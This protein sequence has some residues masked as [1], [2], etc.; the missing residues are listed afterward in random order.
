MYVQIRFTLSGKFKIVPVD[1]L[2][3][4]KPNCPTKIC[5]AKDGD[6]YLKALVISVRNSEKE[7]DE[8]AESV[9]RRN[10]PAN[11][12]SELSGDELLST[13]TSKPKEQKEDDTLNIVNQ[14]LFLKNPKTYKFC[15]P[16]Y[17]IMEGKK[18]MYNRLLNPSFDEGDVSLRTRFRY[19]KLMRT[20]EEQQNLEFAPV[21]SQNE[22][23]SFFSFDRDNRSE[24]LQFESDPSSFLQNHLYDTNLQYTSDYCLREDIDS[25]NEAN[26]CEPIVETLS[27][28]S[29]D[30]FEILIP[31]KKPRITET[32]F[33]KIDGSQIDKLPLKLDDVPPGLADTV[34]IPDIDLGHLNTQLGAGKCHQTS[35]M[36]NKEIPSDK[37][38]K[39]LEEKTG[40][41]SVG[42]HRKS[43]KTIHIGEGIYIPKATYD[44]AKLKAKTGSQFVKKMLI[45]IFSPQELLDSSVGGG[46]SNRYK[47]ETQKPPL[48]P[49]RLLAVKSM[50]T[51][52]TFYLTFI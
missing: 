17:N 11:L 26:V 51:T 32:P 36:S 18:Q 24:G 38:S 12:W 33:A 49:T 27:D 7:L 50:L 21:S 39:A 19:R 25:R 42:F 14:R 23:N 1:Q 30:A 5:F 15:P 13:T 37:S 9:R 16:Y 22:D 31:A 8:L 4:Y 44:A 45:P 6:V 3:K 20:V 47:K 34:L 10:P 43:D 40:V 52:L 2:K 46:K 41:P 28:Y 29:D 48:D 35:V